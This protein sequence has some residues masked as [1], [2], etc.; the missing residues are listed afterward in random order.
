MIEVPRLPPPFG[1]VGRNRP[2]SN[3]YESPAY[4]GLLR[5]GLAHPP[6]LTRVRRDRLPLGYRLPCPPL[7]PD[8]HA[9]S[10]SHALCGGHAK[11]GGFRCGECCLRCHRFNLRS[12]SPG[13][14]RRPG[15]RL[16]GLLHRQLPA[17]PDHLPVDRCLAEG[18]RLHHW[19]G[20]RSI[21]PGHGDTGRHR[22]GEGQG[23]GRKPAGCP[24]NH[25]YR[26]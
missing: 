4:P 5:S 13:H 19:V 21:A 20:R 8:P 24:Q 15:R 18:L 26:W 14:R 1:K 9:H 10:H 17:G 22:L 25:L 23:P 6:E 11:S 7:H 3:A 12:R 16:G 2:D